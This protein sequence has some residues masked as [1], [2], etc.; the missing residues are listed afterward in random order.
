MPVGRITFYAKKMMQHPVIG[1]DV[2]QGRHEAD[3]NEL[4]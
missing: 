1:F 2:S 3:T 4:I